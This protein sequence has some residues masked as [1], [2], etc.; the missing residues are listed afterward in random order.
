MISDSSTNPNEPLENSAIEGDG[1]RTPTNGTPSPAALAEE[2]Q[3]KLQESEKKYLYLYSEFENFRR[4]IER[5]RL[6]YIKFG[7]EGFLKELLQVLDNFERALAHAKS[8]GGEK[9]SPLALVVQGIEMIH[10]QFAEA[11]K[12]QGVTA[13][14]SVGQKF[15][16]TLHEAVG[17]EESKSEPGTIVKEMQKGYQLHGRLLRPARVVVAK[18]QQ[19]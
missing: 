16:P 2:L 9:G 4:R 1:D 5:D 10:Y 6:D 3:L 7:H 12:A 15:D 18:A 19:K 14:P 17:E 8:Q 13:V 11:L